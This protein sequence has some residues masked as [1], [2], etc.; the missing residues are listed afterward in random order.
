MGF[1]LDLK[2]QVLGHWSGDETL[3]VP[4]SS[5]LP[6]DNSHGSTK[7]HELVFVLSTYIFIQFSAAF[8]L[9]RGDGNSEIYTIE[10]DHASKNHRAILE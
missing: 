5:L 7:K 4:H 10:T 9:M 2:Q 6:D 8:K 3:P 1:A